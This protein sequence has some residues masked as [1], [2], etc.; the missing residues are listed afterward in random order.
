MRFQ[1]WDYES[2]AHTDRMY[3][4]RMEE[5]LSLV[6]PY[7]ASAGAMINIELKNGGVRYEGME[8][9]I[10]ALVKKYHMESH[11]L[12][13]SFNP[14]SIRMLKELDAG[15]S[16]GIL[17]GDVRVCVDMEGDCLADAIHP[18]AESILKYGVHSGKNGNVQERVP[19]GAE[20]A[21]ENG[22]A[23]GASCRP[24]R[25]WNGS[26]PFYKERRYPVQYDLCALAKKGMTDFITNV[27]E[28]YLRQD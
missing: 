28:E 7:S 18:S 27:P 21:L 14:E 13:S 11:V 24:V 4:P 2:E 9:K 5:V 8:E 16:A 19:S 25:G 3:I 15:V 20:G 22:C 26:E 12:Y 17:A 10:L 1:A 6:K 23:S